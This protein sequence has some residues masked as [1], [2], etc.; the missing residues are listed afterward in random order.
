MPPLLPKYIRFE[1]PSLV[2]HQEMNYP[3]FMTLAR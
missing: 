2:R 1:S 3:T